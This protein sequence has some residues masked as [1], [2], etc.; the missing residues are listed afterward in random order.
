M[1]CERDCACGGV[2]FF[3]RRCEGDC[4]CG[5][6]RLSWMRC[7]RGRAFD[8]VPLLWSRSDRVSGEYVE[9]VA[10]RRWRAVSSDVV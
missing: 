3:W 9:Y 4:G 2:Q 6:V 5:G 10:R 7:E 1:R 8:D